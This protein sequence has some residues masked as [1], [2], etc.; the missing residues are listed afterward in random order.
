MFLSLLFAFRHFCASANLLEAR[1]VP[2]T[3]F[4]GHVS[5]VLPAIANPPRRFCANAGVALSDR[6]ARSF[7]RCVPGD[8]GHFDGN[9]LATASGAIIPP[10][11][12]AT[13]SERRQSENP[14]S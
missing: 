13:T 11:A 9:G 1:F 8:C 14:P 7:T 3:P 2:A 5:S 10:T 12:A 4:S 6:G